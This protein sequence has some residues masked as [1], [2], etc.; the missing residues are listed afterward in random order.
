MIPVLYYKSTENSP[1]KEYFDSKYFTVIEFSDL[2]NLTK[3]LTT[4][5]K[6]FPKKSCIYI[7]DTMIT[8]LIPSQLSKLCDS[9]ETSTVDIFYLNKYG[10]LCNLYVTV[11]PK[12]NLYRTFSPQGFEAVMFTSKGLDKFLEVNFE[13]PENTGK[14][15]P[16]V[17]NQLVKT[18]YF[19]SITTL[20]NIFTFNVV[21]YGKN[22]SNFKLLCECV[23]NPG[24][25]PSTG[26]SPVIYIYVIGIIILILLIAW[27]LY[28]IGPKTVKTKSP[29]ILKDA[30]GSRYQKINQKK[31]DQPQLG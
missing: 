20:G 10:D 12:N 5:K 28:K 17:T 22:N 14:T 6:N 24:T 26:V 13:S 4:I 1:L 30:T 27:A 8:N 31:P 19:Y 11:D 25:V 23:E 29:D 3:E 9:I 21:L 18:G 2:N 15:I 16:E 7:H